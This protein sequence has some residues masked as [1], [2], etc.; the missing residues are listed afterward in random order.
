MDIGILA[1]KRPVFGLSTSL[2]R[3]VIGLSIYLSR[4]QPNEFGI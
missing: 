4:T 3:F 2:R 1:D